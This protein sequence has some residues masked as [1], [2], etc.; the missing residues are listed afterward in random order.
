M[1]ETHPDADLHDTG[2][3]VLVEA[4]PLVARGFPI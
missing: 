2:T 4:Q 3:G 1:L